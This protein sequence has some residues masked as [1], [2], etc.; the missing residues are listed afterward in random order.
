MVQMVFSTASNETRA[1]DANKIKRMLNNLGV[2]QILLSCNK[3]CHWN[4]QVTCWLN[5]IIMAIFNDTCCNI[6]NF[7]HYLVLRVYDVRMS[8]YCLV[9]KSFLD[10]DC[11]FARRLNNN[12]DKLLIKIIPSLA[13]EEYR[14]RQARF[15]QFL[16]STRLGFM[17]ETRASS[18]H[19]A[20]TL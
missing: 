11:F 1:H 9:L 17:N 3:K 20:R 14:T 2:S 19:H 5:Y 13:L 18:P 4:R 7:L 15:R 10:S 12:N 16:H 8:F 6:N